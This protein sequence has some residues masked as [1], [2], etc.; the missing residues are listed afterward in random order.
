MATFSVDDRSGQYPSAG[1]S[2]LSPENNHPATAAKEAGVEV[3][4][5]PPEPHQRAHSPQLAA[6]L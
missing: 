3:R 2:A 4:N 1:V 6:G 5:R